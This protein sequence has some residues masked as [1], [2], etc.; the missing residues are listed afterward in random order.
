MDKILGSFSKM[1]TVLTQ[2]LRRVLIVEDEVIIASDLAYL[3][4]NNGYQV[5]GMAVNGT[6]AVDIALN[7][8]PDVILMDIDLPGSLD[9]IEVAH[10]IQKKIVTKII[11]TSGHYDQDP[12]IQRLLND[13]NAKFIQKPYYDDIIEKLIQDL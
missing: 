3:L 11:Y 8:E 13:E 1:N 7:T 10:L 5:V 12:R 4:E 9:G 2:S 6:Q